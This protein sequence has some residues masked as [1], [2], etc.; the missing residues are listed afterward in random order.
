M[1]VLVCDDDIVVLKV[2]HVVMEM[3]GAEAIFV[4]DGRKA[5]EHLREESF[6]LIITDIHMPHYNGDDILKLVRDEQKRNTPIVMIS[7]DTNEE[8]ITL[9][10]KQGVA[11]FIKKPIDATSL[12]Q[13]LKKF[14]RP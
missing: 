1:K 8:V 12:Q 6:D 4:K 5:L 11:E 9:A 10:L 3:E 13:K 14:L 2:I 7:S